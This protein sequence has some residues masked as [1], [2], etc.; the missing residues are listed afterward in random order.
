MSLKVV[1]LAP[2]IKKDEPDCLLEDVIR[3]INAWGDREAQK[4]AKK[5]GYEYTASGLKSKN[6][7]KPN[8]KLKSST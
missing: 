6:N 1:H 3:L 5:Y 2:Q 8:K 4:I 7:H